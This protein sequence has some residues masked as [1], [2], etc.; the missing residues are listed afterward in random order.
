MRS[1]SKLVNNLESKKFYKVQTKLDLV[2]RANDIKEASFLAEESTQSFNEKSDFQ[3]L[4]VQE[5]TKNEYNELLVNDTL[6]INLKNVKENADVTYNIVQED[7]IC[8]IDNRGKLTALK[9]ES[10]NKII[11]QFSF[12]LYHTPIKS[13]CPK[14]L[15]DKILNSKKYIIKFRLFIIF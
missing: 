2:L 4:K 7:K 13:A 10:D 9:V 14:L 1:F 8:Y 12:L 3:I 5:V 11:L 15:Q 6:Y